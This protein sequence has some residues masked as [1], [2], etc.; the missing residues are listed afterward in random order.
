LT[1]F[2]AGGKVSEVHAAAAC[3]Y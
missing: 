2:L 3:C 1:S